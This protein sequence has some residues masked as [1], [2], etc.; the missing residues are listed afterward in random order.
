MQLLHLGCFDRVFPNWVNA[1]ITPHLFVGRV[2]GMPWLLYKA[3]VMS[4]ERYRQH[5][6]G[7]FRQIKYL[8]ATKRFPFRARR[9]LPWRYDR[10]GGAIEPSAKA[11]A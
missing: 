6:E 9:F 8:N 4:E 3:R 10:E 7:L 5:R 11:F 1:D 2:P